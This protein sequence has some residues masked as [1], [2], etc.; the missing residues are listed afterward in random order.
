M[1]FDITPYRRDKNI[2]K[3]YNERIEVLPDDAW[4]I[5]RDGDCMYLTP[6]YGSIIEKT[7]ENHGEHYALFGALTNRL[8]ME[9][10]CYLQRFNTDT[11]VKNH[12]P[13]A[14]ELGGKEHVVPVNLVAGFFMMFKKSTWK[15]VGGF[16]ENS[17]HADQEFS[18]S[19]LAK[20]MKIGQIQ[21][22]YLF[23][24]YRI[25]QDTHAGAWKD[26]SHLK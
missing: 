10:L 7:I 9:R 17:I 23:H 5:V 25:W 19:I 16:K 3:A 13:I 24:S 6:D 18:K 1:I 15:E 8:G 4:I 12:Y 20:G 11:D 2:G 26:V 14:V 22:L 21:G